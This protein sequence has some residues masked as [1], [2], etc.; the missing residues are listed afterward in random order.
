[1]VSDFRKEA[2]EEFEK[3]QSLCTQCKRGN[4]KNLKEWQL[5]VVDLIAESALSMYFLQQIEGEAD[6]WFQNEGKSADSIAIEKLKK[7]IRN[8]YYALRAVNESFIDIDT[9]IRFRLGLVT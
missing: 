9:T 4:F 5:A 7:E 6:T 2:K 3:V 8:M 1:M